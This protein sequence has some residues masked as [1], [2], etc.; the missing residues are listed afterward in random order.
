MRRIE[1]LSEI[2]A[3]GERIVFP[4]AGGYVGIIKLVR[5]VEDREYLE[6][7]VDID[8][9]EFKDFYKKRY[10]TSGKWS[11]RAYCSYKTSA[12]SMFKNFVTSVNKSNPGLDFQN[13]NFDEQSLVGMRIG[14][15]L[16]EEEYI[17]RDGDIGE[18]LKINL[19]HT[20]DAIHK[21]EFKVP[22]KLKVEKPSQ[23]SKPH[24]ST[25]LSLDDVDDIAF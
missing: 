11:L 13:G 15:T 16:R 21:G 2:S 25:S 23:E 19:W 8:E 24:N 6:M 9:G 7:L 10:E 3:Y 12:L 1:N 14:M 4:P 18:S 17:K 22:E 20:I 5:D